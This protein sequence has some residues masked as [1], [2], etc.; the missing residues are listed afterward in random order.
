MVCRFE[1]VNDICALTQRCCA[2]KQKNAQL[3]KLAKLC[4]CSHFPVMLSHVALRG[5][6]Y[7]SLPARRRGN[8]ELPH[9][10]RAGGVH[11]F[12]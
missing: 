2:K 6:S 4:R 12:V 1:L 9:V 7:L 11:S 5:L 8:L 3:A 10:G